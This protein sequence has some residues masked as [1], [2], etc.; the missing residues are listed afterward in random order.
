MRIYNEPMSNIK[1]I[2]VSEFRG[3]KSYRFGTWFITVTRTTESTRQGCG[4]RH[5]ET[6]TTWRAKHDDGREA[7]AGYGGIRDAVRKL[8]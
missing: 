6:F 7:L 8:A 4:L 3:V 1:P 5:N 2:K